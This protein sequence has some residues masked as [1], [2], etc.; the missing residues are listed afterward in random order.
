MIYV[1]MPYSEEVK[2]RT[3]ADLIQVFRYEMRD[4]VDFIPCEGALVPNQRI[5][6]VREAR[7]RGGSH[8]LFLDS[9]M[10]FPQNILG[11][12]LRHN[13][14]IVACNCID[15]RTGLPVLQ[16]ADDG[17]VYIGLAVMLIDLSVFDRIKE[18]WFALPWDPSQ[19]RLVGEDMFFC[20]KAH[21]AGYKI[22]IDHELSKEVRHIGQGEFGMEGE[23]DD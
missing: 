6:L 3:M 19:N 15:K 16:T 21:E 17:A 4:V 13:E 20:R 22:V 11:R 23:E 8:V 14:F 10:R 7:R 18:P 1:C 12:L 5:S 9:D 2:G